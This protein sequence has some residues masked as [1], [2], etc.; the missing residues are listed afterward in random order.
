MTGWMGWIIAAVLL[1]AGAGVTLLLYRSLGREKEAMRLFREGDKRRALRRKR[2]FDVLQVLGDALQNGQPESTLHRLITQGAAGVVEAEGAVLYLLDDKGMALVPRH[3]TKDCPPLIALPERIINQAKTNAGTLASFLRL[4]SI[5]PGEGVIG[6]IFQ[7]LQEENIP[8]LRHHPKFDGKA[9][10]FQQHVAALI[11][12][13]KHGGRGLGVLAAASERSKPFSPHELE[14]FDA[15]ASQCGFA[16]GNAQAHMEAGAKRKLE[17]ELR[18]ASEIQRI[19]LPERAPETSGWEMAARNVPARLVSGDYYDFVPIDTAHWGV[20]IADVCGKGIPAALITAMCRSVL[21]SNARET[22]SPSH[23]LAAVN[24]NLFPDIREDMFITV[25][26]AVLASDGASLTLSRA[27]HTPPL[28]W[29]KA[30]GKVE[31]IS[32]PGVAVGVD[33]GAVFERITKDVNIPMESGDV[34]L[35]YTDGVNEAVD[36]KE[37][38]FGEERIKTILGLAAPNG[39]EAVVSAICDSVKKFIGGEPQSDDITLVVVCRK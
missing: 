31:V 38:E 10:P 28:L 36:H 18:N 19:L 2:V 20:A 26:Y 21:R 9:N 13:L 25:S 4:H 17:G 33:K 37:L 35:L 6:S 29:R 27:G 14:M 23:V 39:A 8:D 7:S 15:L 32:A 34:L 30:S 1:L 16:L 5:K 11:A 3:C 24:R 22:L 12:P